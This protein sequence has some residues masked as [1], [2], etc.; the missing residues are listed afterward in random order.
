MAGE[1]IMSVAYGIDVR[2]TDDPYVT[3]AHKAVHTFSIAA[4]PGL[5]LVV[6]AMHPQNVARRPQFDKQDTFPILKHVPTW[7]PLA[8]FKRQAAEW[9]KLSRSM[10]EMPFAETKRQMVRCRFDYPKYGI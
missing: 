7:F 3:L 10:L 5:Y 6:S 1:I 9:R 8:G 2:P 4:V